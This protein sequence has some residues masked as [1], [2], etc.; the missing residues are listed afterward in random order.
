MVLE[1]LG[2][3][4]KK[5]TNKISKAIFVDKAIIDE[6][7]RELQRALIGADVNIHLVKEITDRIKLGT[8]PIL[9]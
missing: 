4:L 8:L 2:E 1:K 9:I 7:A 5:A 6:V 3:A